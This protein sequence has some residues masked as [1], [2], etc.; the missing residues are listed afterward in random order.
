MTLSESQQSGPGLAPSPLIAV[1]WLVTLAASTLPDA[2]CLQFTGATLPWLFWGKAGLLLVLIAA[3]WAWANVRPL[4]IY[5]I[6]LLVHLATWHL[7]SWVRTI[8][9]W[10]RWEEHNAWVTGLAAI[11]LLK[12][13]VALITIAV[14][15]ALMRR[16]ESF[17]LVGGQ[18]DA[19]A[20]PVRWLGMKGPITWQTLGPIVAVAGTVIIAV[21][22]GLSN[23]PTG[24][25]LVKALPLLPAAV[26]FAATNAFSEEVSF[27]SAL[28]APLHGVV[29]KG[30][31]MALTAVFFGLA[32][33]S[34]GVPLA[35]V[36]TVLMTGFLGWLMGK[37]MLETRGFRWPWLIHF[38]NDI[39]VFVFLALGSV[40]TI[41]Q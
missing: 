5:F 12:I 29:G 23:P 9:A 13:G 39:P 22:M 17:F 36:P 21:V 30:Q 32:H 33:Y 2:I 25:T 41:S 1:A 34:G 4:R 27:R 11:Q 3:T 8:P 16:R 19:D 37:S 26:L 14:L 15:F 31:A 38:V 18:R 28:L 20:E 35:T 24:A 7:F 6:L 40:T 10:A